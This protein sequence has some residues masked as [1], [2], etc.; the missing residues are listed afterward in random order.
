MDTKPIV[1][2]IVF[3]FGVYIFLEIP[4]KPH[5]EKE[6]IQPQRNLNGSGYG[7]EGATGATQKH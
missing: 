6:Q 7:I 1:F 5:S 4:P 3:F 2:I